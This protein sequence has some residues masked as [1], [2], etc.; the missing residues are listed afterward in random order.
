V[1]FDLGVYDLDLRASV[2]AQREYLRTRPRQAP[3]A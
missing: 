3:K 1:A 2:A